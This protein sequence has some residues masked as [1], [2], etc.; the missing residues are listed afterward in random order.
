MWISALSADGNID[1]CFTD[2]WLA[3]L[4]VLP[5]DGNVISVLPAD[6]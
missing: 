1:F 3:A 4:S 2:R 6:G 5:T